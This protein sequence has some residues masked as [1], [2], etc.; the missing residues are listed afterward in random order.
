[1][2]DSTKMLGLI[3][4][5]VIKWS[6]EAP[7]AHSEHFALLPALMMDQLVDE[8]Y[9]IKNE[10]G[11]WGDNGRVE[12]TRADRKEFVDISRAR[13][14]DLALDEGMFDV[15][16]YYAEDTGY[17]KHL[18]KRSNSTKIGITIDSAKL[19]REATKN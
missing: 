2:F 11:K 6:T 15:E 17:K 10:F 8:G 4:G 14:V 5:Y 1:M 18:R 12:Q 9:E 16:T 7:G 19:S 13:D 3:A